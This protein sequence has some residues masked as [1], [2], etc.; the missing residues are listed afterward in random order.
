MYQNLFHNAISRFYRDLI[1]QTEGGAIRSWVQCDIRYEQENERKLC[2]STPCPFLIRP[3]VRPFLPFCTSVRPSHHSFI[4][5]PSIRSFL[6]LNIHF[7]FARFSR[8]SIDG[9]Q[10]I[11]VP[12]RIASQS[13]R[14]NSLTAIDYL[15][16]PQMESIIQRIHDFSGITVGRGEVREWAEKTVFIRPSLRLSVRPSVLLSLFFVRPRVLSFDLSV[17]PFRSS[18][19]PITHFVHFEF[20]LLSFFGSETICRFWVRE[21]NKRK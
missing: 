5:P 4:H 10:I 16:L 7:H 6:V 14:D 11:D 9:E 12:M 15:L 1:L 3:S 17:R 8:R 18:L 19:I 13:F 20:S 2:P 21:A